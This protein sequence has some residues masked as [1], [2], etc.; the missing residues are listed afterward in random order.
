MKF[1][2]KTMKANVFTIRYCF[3]YTDIL[4]GSVLG[5]VHILKLDKLRVNGHLVYVINF[6][7]LYLIMLK[8]VSVF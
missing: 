1:K 8:S 2:A 4:E 7:D 3:L 6:A 5:H